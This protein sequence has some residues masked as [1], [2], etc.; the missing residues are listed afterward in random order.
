MDAAH[1][2]AK[3][4]KVQL[5][6]RSAYQQHFLDLCELLGHPKP[7][8]IDPKG[9]FFTFERG[10]AKSTGHRGWADVWKRNHFAI[11]YKGSTRTSTPPTTSSCSTAA[12]WRT[13]R[14]CG[15]GEEAQRTLREL[16]RGVGT[17]D[18]YRLI[19]VRGEVVSYFR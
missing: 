15:S 2:A 19:E 16:R 12:A 14:S 17:Y 11:E 7:A 4:Q 13:R 5:T 9:E 10:A 3:W 18:E 6:E 1:F 8:E